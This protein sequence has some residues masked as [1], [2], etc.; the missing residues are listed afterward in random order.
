MNTKKIKQ[1]I[2]ELIYFVQGE[3]SIFIRI[4]LDIFLLLLSFSLS[5]DIYRFN[6]SCLMRNKNKKKIFA[7]L[8]NEKDV[9]MNSAAAA[10]SRN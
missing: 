5:Q 7:I 10:T 1:Q 4:Q 9:I 6:F 3:F 2:L 8:F